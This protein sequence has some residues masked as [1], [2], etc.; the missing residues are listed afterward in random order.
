MVDGDAGVVVYE[1]MAAVADGEGGFIVVVVL[2]YRI[3]SVG[4]V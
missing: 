2:V 4:C 1:M 3:V